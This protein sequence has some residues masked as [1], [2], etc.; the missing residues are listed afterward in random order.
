MKQFLHFILDL[1]KKIGLSPPQD[2]QKLSDVEVAQRFISGI[3]E[4]FFQTHNEIGTTEFQDEEFQYFSEFHKFWEA[5]HD[6]ILNAR[7]DPIQTAIAAKSLRSAMKRY[8]REVFAVTLD[9]KGLSPEAIAQV[10]FL[11]ANQDFREPPENQYGKYLEDPTQ[12]E[13]S[14]IREDPADFLQFLGMTRLSQTDKRIDFARNAATFL[15]ENAIRAF[16]I[17]KHFGNNAVEIRGAL[18]DSPNMGYGTKKANMFI[19]DMVELNVWPGLSHYDEIDVA[20]DINTM[21]LALRTGIIKTDIPLVSSF[22]DVFCWQYGYI[23]EMSASAWRKVWEDW[24]T[25][26]HKTAPRSPCLMDFLLYRIGREYCGDI[27]VRYSCENGH[28]FFHFGARLRNCRICLTQ[29]KRVAATSGS[30]VLPCQITAAELPREKGILLLEKDKLLRI[31]DGV[32]IFEESCS[33]KSPSFRPLD[34]PK[35]ISIKGQTSWTNSYAER[36][37]GGGGMMG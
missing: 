20:S 3:N 4:Y 34:P 36:D 27:V 28:T 6:E 5:H 10:R 15:T 7:I 23:D 21:K 12:F 26:D 16:E 13:A 8:G 2:W 19:R 24:Y 11:T 22:L 9:T 33:P 37:R 1:N 31:F 17:A 35:S 18:I 14:T 30:R 29:G 32:C 25:L